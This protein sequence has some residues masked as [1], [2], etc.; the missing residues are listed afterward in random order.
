LQILA[1]DVGT[2]TQD[3][4]LYD[5]EREPENALQMIMPAQTQIMAA[6]IRRA[7]GAGE[8]VAL[9]GATMGGGPCNYAVQQHLKAGRKA[10]ATPAAACTI[11]DD[12]VA[13]M[14]MGVRLISEDEAERLRGV[15]RLVLRDLDM[16]ALREAFGIFG[17][18]LEPAAIGVAVFD[19]GAAPPGYSDRRFR[20]EY[21][22]GRL[23]DEPTLTALA[24]LRDEIPPQMTRM[25][26]AAEEAGAVRRALVMDT[27][28]A[29]ML[30]ALED[31]RVREAGA[32]L[33]VNA[34]NSH[35]L[36]FRLEEGR[37]T[38]LFEHHTGRLTTER[39]DDLLGKLADGSIK[40]D[41]VYDDHG[42]GALLLESRPMRP[43]LVSVTGPRRALLTNSRWRPYFAVPY[44]DMMVAGCWGLVRALALKA[45][46]LAEI[47]PRP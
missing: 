18:R 8:D 45:P 16:D 21:L 35:T 47:L 28:S 31:S 37:I 14:R 46:E 15:R 23:E 44:G 20:F 12:L 32:A 10:Y 42:H 5:T 13:V 6:A 17:V 38:G 26:A 40:N 25:A 29:A 43:A 2:G 9:V 3:I 36:A 30:G 39:L 4:L 41:E 22:T 11:D 24:F 1:V 27:P 7:T 33:L 34:G 19:H